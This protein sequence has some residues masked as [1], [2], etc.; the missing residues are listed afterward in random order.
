MRNKQKAA[1]EKI[2]GKPWDSWCEEAVR[3]Y[4][5]YTD[6]GFRVEVSEAAQKDLDELLFAHKF[7]SVIV[8]MWKEDFRSGLL[9]LDDFINEP[10]PENYIRHAF[11]IYRDVLG[12]IPSR[13][14]E[15]ADHLEVER[16]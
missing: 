11:E 1:L 15:Y 2:T 4:F 12:Y 14:K 9:F 8:E 7:H 6:R 10:Y 13:Y 16:V 3:A 5:S